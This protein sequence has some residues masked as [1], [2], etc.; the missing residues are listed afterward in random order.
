MLPHPHWEK[1]PCFLSLSFLAHLLSVLSRRVTLETQKAR[2]AGQWLFEGDWKA[3]KTSLIPSLSR[4]PQPL[5][6]HS[7]SGDS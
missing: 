7:R 6:G 3:S 5:K 4:M 2:G 1:V